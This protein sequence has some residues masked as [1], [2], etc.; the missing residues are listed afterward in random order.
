M[1]EGNDEFA[2]AKYFCSYFSRDFL[3]AAKYY[4]MGLLAGA[5][6]LNFETTK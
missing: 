1:G 5:L 6:S 2:L 4:D 3:H